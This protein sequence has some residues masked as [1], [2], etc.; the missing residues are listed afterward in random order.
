MA[1][2]GERQTGL[3]HPT[4]EHGLSSVVKGNDSGQYPKDAYLLFEPDAEA[5]CE[6]SLSSQVSSFR[7]GLVHHGSQGPSVC[8]PGGGAGARPGLQ[9]SLPPA[10]VLTWNRPASAFLRVRK[11]NRA[12]CPLIRLARVTSAFLPRGFSS[13][14]TP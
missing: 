1:G 10:L 9:A 13:A 4:T 5:Y 2:E 7:E 3:P 8:K 12:G 6:Q 14:S 11:G